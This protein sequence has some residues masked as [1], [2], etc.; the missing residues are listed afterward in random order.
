MSTE[1]LISLALG[2]LLLC[3]AV[4]AHNRLV[5]LRNAVGQEYGLIDAQLRQRQDLIAPWL[6]AGD[7]LDPDVLQAL[8]DAVRGARTAMDLAR[9]RPSGGPEAQ[10]LQQAEQRLDAQLAGLWDSPFT[11]HAVRADPALR[12]S[13]LDLVQLEG[14]MDLVA[15]SYNRAVDSYNE[16]VQEFPAWLIARLAGLKALPGLHLGR[17]AAA[18]EAA[19]PLMLG[20]REGD[21]PLSSMLL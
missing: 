16:A 20:R 12:Q 15:E 9:Q 13:V 17:H 2:V 10:A 8:G 19:R 3:W 7:R 4:G 18:R 1:L 11:R 14:R 6:Q 21:A 5:R